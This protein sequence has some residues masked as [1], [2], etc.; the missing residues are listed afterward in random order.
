MHRVEANE[1]WSLFCPS[2]APGL[3]DV[4]GDAFDSLYTKY[5][6]EG[7]AKK[8]IKAQQLWFSI[9]EAQ[10]MLTYSHDFALVPSQT[11]ESYLALQEST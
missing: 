9:L 5:E 7:R 10:V 3:A 8:V 4:W 2:E 11:D 6:R 1:E